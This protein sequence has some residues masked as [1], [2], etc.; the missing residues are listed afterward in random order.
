MLPLKLCC[1]IH[2]N[3]CVCVLVHSKHVTNNVGVCCSK[4]EAVLLAA[5]IS[6]LSPG[7]LNLGRNSY[8]LED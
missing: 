6:F 7:M 8:R 2:C 5:S 3:V 4:V 1:H